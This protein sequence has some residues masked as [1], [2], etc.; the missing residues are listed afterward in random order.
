MAE[1]TDWVPSEPG[2]GRR[3]D[4]AGRGSPAD[5]APRRA[6]DLRRMSYR[7]RSPTLHR[8]RGRVLARGGGDR[9]SRAQRATTGNAKSRIG[10]W[11]AHI[12]TELAR[13]VKA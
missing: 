12:A 4:G 11:E 13:P 9:I 2:A 7:N 8:R 10:A 3:G 6:P 1:S 5:R